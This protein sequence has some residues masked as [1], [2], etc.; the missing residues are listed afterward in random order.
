MTFPAPD[1]TLPKALNQVLALC[2]HIWSRHVLYIQ[3]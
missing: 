2:E 3:I 1:T